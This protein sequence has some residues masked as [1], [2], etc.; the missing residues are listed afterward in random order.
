[1]EIHCAVPGTDVDFGD[2][3]AGLTNVTALLMLPKLFVRTRLAGPG[4]SVPHVGSMVS[5]VVPSGLVVVL[6]TLT[7]LDEPDCS[8]VTPMARPAST[9]VDG[10][11]IG[12]RFG[13]HLI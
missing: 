11:P 13:L 6:L 4:V 9:T 8:S 3:K 1:M 12:S 2:E 5:H 7:G 10:V